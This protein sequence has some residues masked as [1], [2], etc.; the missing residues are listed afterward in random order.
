[1]RLLYVQKFRERNQDLY[2]EGERTK[3]AMSAEGR[4]NENLTTKLTGDHS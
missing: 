1:M 4:L 2:L 3:M